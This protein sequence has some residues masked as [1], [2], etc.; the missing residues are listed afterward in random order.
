VI[1]PA[2]GK[3][4]KITSKTSIEQP[5]YGSSLVADPPAKKLDALCHGHL[6]MQNPEKI[7]ATKIPQKRE[8]LRSPP[9]VDADLAA[10]RNGLTPTPPRAMTKLSDATWFATSAGPWRKPA[11][12]CARQYPLQ[13]QP[14]PH[15]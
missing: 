15:S 5:T 10:Q 4:I 12:L 14:Q 3:K 9:S 1:A 8:G 11:K 7:R 13:P 2:R 6:A